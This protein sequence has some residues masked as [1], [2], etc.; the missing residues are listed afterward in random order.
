MDSV[1]DSVSN[2]GSSIVIDCSGA[3]VVG[4]HMAGNG[5]EALLCAWLK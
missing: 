5:M 3:D 1:D 4:E 2:V